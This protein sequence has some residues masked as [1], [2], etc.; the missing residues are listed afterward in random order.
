VRLFGLGG[1]GRLSIAPQIAV[2]AL[3]IGLAGAMAIEPTRQLFEQRTRIA[4]MSHELKSIEKSNE[5]LE[6]MVTRLQDPDYLEQQARAQSGLVRPGETSII[7][8]PPADVEAT[9][10]EE[11]DVEEAAPSEDAGLIDSMLNFLGFG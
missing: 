3:V 8:M 2:V 11:P 9:E 7:V 5:R 4:D 1:G 10:K 6:N